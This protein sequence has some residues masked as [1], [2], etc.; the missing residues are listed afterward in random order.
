MQSKKEVADLQ[1]Y[2]FFYPI[3]KDARASLASFVYL[4]YKQKS[5]RIDIDHYMLL[6]MPG[7]VPE[8]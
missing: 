3:Q 6:I 5:P 2:K 7:S 4:K 8:W 1:N